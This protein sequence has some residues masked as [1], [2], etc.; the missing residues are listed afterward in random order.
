MMPWRRTARVARPIAV[1]LYSDTVTKPPA[2][3]ARSVDT[4]LAGFGGG[5]PGRADRDPRGLDIGARPLTMDAGR[6]FDPAERPAQAPP[7]EN[8]LPSVVSQDVG[9]ADGESTLSTV[10]STSWG[11]ATSLAG[12]QV[13]TTGRFWG[14]TETQS[15]NVAK[16]FAGAE[17]IS[18]GKG[19][20]DRAT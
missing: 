2:G 16:P 15:L 1:D 11:V 9:H 4:G 12:F 7:G 19:R 10:A 20:L 17:I 18:T 5:R 3:F 13:S 8:L 14:S 6:L